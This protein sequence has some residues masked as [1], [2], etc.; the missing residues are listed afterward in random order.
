[1]HKSL[2]LRTNYALAMA[3]AVVLAWCLALGAGRQLLLLSLFLLAGIASGRLQGRAIRSE[4]S[5]FMVAE[6]WS[7]VRAALAKSLSGKLS[8]ALTWAN[9]IGIL[10][11]MILLEPTPAASIV[12]AAYAAFMLAR[13]LMALPALHRLDALR[14]SESAA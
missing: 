3:M 12:I 13:E 5:A 8:L 9:A 14:R 11:V 7:A 10:L 4:P 2:T 6:S 1:M